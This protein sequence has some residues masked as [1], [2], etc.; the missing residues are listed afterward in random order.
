MEISKNQEF[1]RPINK[2]T[3][4]SMTII[5]P[6]VKEREIAMDFTSHAPADEIL[7]TGMT[8]PD[9]RKN[10]KSGRLLFPIIPEVSNP[11]RVQIPVAQTGILPCRKTWGTSEKRR[12]NKLRSCVDRLPGLLFDRNSMNFSEFMQASDE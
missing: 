11:F 3:D 7:N 1:D 2:G 8:T 6:S 4:Q 9:V 12:S 10:D 5:T